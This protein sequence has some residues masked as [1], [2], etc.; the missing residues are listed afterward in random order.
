MRELWIVEYEAGE[1]VAVWAICLTWEQAE[2]AQHR[3]RVEGK[4]G[5]RIVRYVREGTVTRAGSVREHSPALPTRNAAGAS[6]R[7]KRR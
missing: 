2:T 6:L 5:T 3:A 4:R 7:S 1:K